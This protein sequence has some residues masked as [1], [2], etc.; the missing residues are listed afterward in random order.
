LTGK[1]ER[2]DPQKL[3][4]NAGTAFV[5]TYVLGMG[6]TLTPEERDALVKKNKRNAQRIFPY[7][8]GQEVNASPT[9]NFDRYVISFGEMSLEEAEAWPDLLEIVREKV[10]PER[11]KNKRANYR[12]KWWLFGEYRPGLFRALAPLSRCLVACAVTKHLSFSFQTTEQIFDQRLYVFPIDALSGFSVLQSRIHEAWARLLSA[13]L[14]TDLTY[15]GSRCFDTFPFPK[16][17]PRAKHPA[18]ERAGEKLYEARAK[19]MIDTQQGLTKTYNAL[20]DPD[21]TDRTVLKLRELHESM[22][23]AVLDAYGWE[24][25]HVPPYGMVD[26]NWEFSIIERLYELNAARSLG[27]TQPLEPLL[28]LGREHPVRP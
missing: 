2:D 12:D 13:T 15:S 16:P 3:V 26:R 14:K 22:D 21:C 6:F 17:D 20:K 25:L 1:L 7:L 11:D 8:G 4:T 10:K 19:F 23:R 9:Q 18:L 24:D 5:G 27:P 28:I